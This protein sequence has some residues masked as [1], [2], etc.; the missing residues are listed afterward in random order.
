MQKSKKDSKN[1][2]SSG[3]E[4]SPPG[5]PPPPYHPNAS[6]VS[7]NAAQTN[8][9]QRAILSFE[10][11]NETDDE[12]LAEDDGIFRSISM[13]TAPENV[14]YLVVFL[15]FVLS[16]SKPA[17]ILF[18]LITELYKKGNV[19]E[20]RKWAYEIHST[21]LVPTAPLSFFPASDILSESLARDIDDKLAQAKSYQP[22]DRSNQQQDFEMAGLLR[23]V[24]QKSRSK[25]RDIINRQM[26]EFQ[27][28][29]TAGLGTMYGPSGPELAAAKGNKQN[30]TKIVEDFLMPKLTVLLDE[31]DGS[32]AFEES[33]VSSKMALTSA[34]STVV[35]KIFLPRS[36]TAA[37]T[38]R[39]H[40]Y[41]TREKS[42]KS[43]LISKKSKALVR[44]HHLTLRQYYETTNCNH[45]Q[46]LM[47]GVAPQGYACADC[48]LNVHR[49]CAKLLDETCPGPVNVPVDKFT[50]FMDRIREKGHGMQKKQEE[51][52]GATWDDAVTSG[53]LIN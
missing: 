23:N 49:T 44:G 27:E 28:K 38:E 36:G 1:R 35:H 42:F 24:F 26:E 53:K 19:K 5:T 48:G 4:V 16:N 9:E 7:I 40:H 11:D 25:A 45:C 20:M 52:L 13:L 3:A 6:P 37:G 39:V 31:C 46:N 22:Q 30:E 51:E 18:Y 21:F 8:V 50:K 15:N 33:T 41:V 32:A 34:L 12:A 43:R 14:A 29:R 2:E 17:A 47:W 10:C